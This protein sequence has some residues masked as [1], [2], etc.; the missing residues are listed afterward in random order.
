MY[1]NL[2][3]LG[4]LVCRLLSIVVACWSQYENWKWASTTTGKTHSLRM[5]R[6]LNIVSVREFE[7][8]RSRVLHINEV[9]SRQQQINGNK[10]RIHVSIHHLID[11]RNGEKMSKQTE[12]NVFFIFLPSTN[13]LLCFLRINTEKLSHHR[14]LRFLVLLLFCWSILKIWNVFYL[15]SDSVL[16]F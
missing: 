10:F 13:V 4:T 14:Y 7:K 1:V 15:F 16:Y 6:A 5:N 3:L 9:S 12:K 8:L 11:M 2:Q